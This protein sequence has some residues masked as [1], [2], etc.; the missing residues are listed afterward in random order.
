[1][2]GLLKTVEAPAAGDHQLHRLGGDLVVGVADQL[3][4]QFFALARRL[5]LPEAMLLDAA[6]EDVVELGIAQRLRPLEDRQRDRDMGRGQSG[7]K[8][9]MRLETGARG[10]RADRPRCQRTS[11]RQQ[12]APR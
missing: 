6:D 7:V 10:G 2:H 12:A 9:L 5:R 3:E 4:E 11:R 1:M 8:R